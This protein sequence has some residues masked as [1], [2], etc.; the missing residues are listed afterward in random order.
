M[1]LV[2]QKYPRTVWVMKMT[3]AMI[4]SSRSPF[5]QIASDH[6]DRSE[7]TATEWTR[8][9]GRDGICTVICDPLRHCDN[10]PTTSSP[11]TFPPPASLGDTPP[12]VS[13]SPGDYFNPGQSTPTAAAA[14]NAA[15]IPS[16]SYSTLTG[17]A[18]EYSDHH[19][20]NFSADPMSASSG[21]F[22]PTSNW[23]GPQRA[24]S[25]WGQQS[26]EAHPRLLP[27]Y[28][29]SKMPM[30][31]DYQQLSHPSSLR[32]HSPPSAPSSSATFL[33]LSDSNHSPTHSLPRSTNS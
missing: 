4:E 26:S 24:S 15:F 6:R 5:A 17:W 11:T 33:Q 14:S 27:N 7:E 18:G 32:L 2:R 20:G 19:H 12:I 3:P 30:Y 29:D 22:S 31:P 25:T 9:P 16:S 21:W 23:Q 13:P 1:G 8:N 28:T 10:S